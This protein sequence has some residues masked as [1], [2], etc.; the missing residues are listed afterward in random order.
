VQDRLRPKVVLATQTRV[1]EAAVDVDGSWVPSTPVI[2]VEPVA[3]EDVW[4]VGAVMLAPPVSAWALANHAG[5]ALAANAI[6]LSAKQAR[7]MPLP[8]DDRAWRAGAVALRSGDIERC[9]AAMTAAYRASDE[10][11]EWWNTRR[12]NNRR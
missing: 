2:S 6:K 12:W 4:R 3:P 11:L 1:L 7:T 8:V 5:A 9:A 10:V